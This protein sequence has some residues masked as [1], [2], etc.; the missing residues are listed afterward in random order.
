MILA[1]GAA[2]AALA[3]LVG[4]DVVEPTVITSDRCGCQLTLPLGIRESEDLHPEADLMAMSAVSEVY[5]IALTEPKDE[6]EPISLD[7]Y[8]DLVVSHMIAT[9]A[10]PMVE[11]DATTVDGLPAIRQQLLGTID[12]QEIVYEVLLLDAAQSFY[13]VVSW[14][15]RSRY[16]G[17]KADMVDMLRSFRVTDTAQR[18]GETRWYTLDYPPA[19]EGLREARAAFTT[20]LREAPNHT[21]SGPAPAPPEGMYEAVKYPAPLGEQAAYLTPDPGDGARH[22]AVLWAHGGFGGIGEWLLDPTPDPANDQTARAL[23][24]AGLVTFIPSWRGENDNPGQLELFYGEVDDL[25]AARDYLAG[26]PYVDPERIYLAGHSSGGTLVLLAAAMDADFRAGFVF[27]GSPDVSAV[28]ADG[29]GYGNTPFDHSRVDEGRLRSAVYFAGDIRRPVFYF[30]G[31]EGVPY[32]MIR[33]M[34]AVA[35]K[36]QA[37]LKVHW[38]AGRGHFDILAP[39]TPLVAAK[40]LADTGPTADITFTDQ[41]LEAALQ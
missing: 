39:L 12:G 27:G 31:Q 22:P 10:Q 34:A 33:G 37:P 13:Q 9:G 5:L 28:V 26:L 16:E 19:A 1:P 30:E 41:E 8:R 36:K 29:V 40:I 38:L 15:L 24:E 11:P 21:P 14:S 23:R 4:C 18:D 17:N 25:L 32:S 35:A 20:Q 2:L 7:G 3:L 6:F